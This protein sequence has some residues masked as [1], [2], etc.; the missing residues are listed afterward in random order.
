M[1][2]IAIH[3][4]QQSAPRSPDPV[5]DRG[6]V[7]NVVRVPDDS[8]SP[9]LCDLSARVRG[10]IIDDDHLCRGKTH[11]LQSIQELPQVLGLIKDRDN[12]GDV[13]GISH[14]SD[15]RNIL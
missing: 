8:G 3:K 2:T 13:A 9:F 1:L 10:A 11:R 7:A 15:K 12:N 5:L 6:P 4:N 14:R